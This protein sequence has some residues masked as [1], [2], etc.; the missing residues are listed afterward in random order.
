MLGTIK[1][2]LMSGPVVEA[3]KEFLRVI[4]LAILPVIIV[5]VEEGALDL[6]IIVVTGLLA[7]LRLV[8]KWLHET[9]KISEDPQLI[10]GLTRF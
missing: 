3:V 1:E 9:G 5:S 8:D 7:G 2:F 10:K 4:A 6:R